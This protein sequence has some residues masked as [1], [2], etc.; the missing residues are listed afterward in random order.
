MGMS[1][2]LG[3]MP[4]GVAFTRMVAGHWSTA[5]RGMAS[6]RRSRARAA[7]RGCVHIRQG[8]PAAFLQDAEGDGPGG[9]AGAQD[10]DVLAGFRLGFGL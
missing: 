2:T 5:S 3:S 4:T 9:A 8:D 6:T 10:E 1:S 7:A